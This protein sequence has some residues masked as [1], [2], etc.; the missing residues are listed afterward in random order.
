MSTA[1]PNHTRRDIQFLRAL[2][3]ASVVVYHFWPNRL[4][5]GFLGVDVF[6]VI[7]GFLIT[8]LILRE[9]ATT[10][11]LSLSR[12]WVRR[13]RRI[14]PAAIVVIIATIIATNGTKLFD[15]VDILGRHVFASAFSFENILLGLDATDYDRRDGL[16]SPLQHYWSLSVEEQFYLVWPILVLIVVWIA[17]R[18]QGN[19]DRL[20]GIVLGVIT[21]ASLIYAIVFAQGVPSMYFDTLARAW[22]L[23]VG[24]AVALWAQRPRESWRWRWI[25]N[26]IGWATLAATFVIPGLSDLAPGIGIIPAVLATGLVLAT[27]PAPSVRTVPFSKPFLAAAEWLGDRS[28]SVYLWHWPIVILLP[29]Y[30]GRELGSVSKLAAIALT[31]VLAELTYRFVENPIRYAKWTW[32]FKPSVVGAVALVTSAAVVAVTFL[33]PQQLGKQEPDDDLAAVM[34]STPNA[35]DAAGTVAEFPYVLPF[36][37][38]AGASVFDCERNATLEFDSAAYP[39]SPPRTSTCQYEKETF[40][41]DC[42]MGDT[43]ASRKIALV[44]DSHARAMWAGL[45]V[46]GKRAGYAVH[47]FL[48]PRCSYRLFHFDWCTEHNLE[49]EPRLNSGEFD[50]VILAQQSSVYDPAKHNPV[51]PFGQLFAELKKNGIPVAVVKDNPS[52]GPELSQCLKLNPDDP[53]SCTRAFDDR[54][55]RATQTGID[56]GFPVINLDNAYCPDNVC[57]AVRGGMFMWRDNGHISPFFHVTAAPFV[58]SQLMEAGLITPQ[59]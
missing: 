16:S 41:V 34:L 48:T 19:V 54:V 49:I 40:I 55:D 33:L 56:L 42:V 47:E 13:I 12:F 53:G 28:Y 29:I 21:S 57:E 26:R 38:G 37:D 22:E 36:C 4:V 35:P 2:A 18:S 39:V 44:G 3:V 46:I 7:S 14:F 27:G 24:A 11:T 10:S 6:F 43:S 15:Q 20:L 32:T 52:R 30:L 59:R 1:A 8:S 45:D 58:W 51:N 25:A 23:A 9:V 17:R 50:L 31:L 5:S